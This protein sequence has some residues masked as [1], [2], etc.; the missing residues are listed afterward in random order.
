M[1]EDRCETCRYAELVPKWRKRPG[2]PRWEPP[3]RIYECRRRSVFYLK[4]HSDWCGEHTPKG[5][6]T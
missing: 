2:H 6:L 4:L 3:S 1:S 5:P